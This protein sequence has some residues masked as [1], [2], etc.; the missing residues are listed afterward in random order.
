MTRSQ[1][2]TLTQINLNDLVS[3]FGWEKQPLPAAI[4]RRIFIRPARTFAQ[5]MV[6]FDSATGQAGLAEAS[7]QTLRAHYVKDLRVHGNKNI[8]ANGPTLFLSNH[9]G[10][11]D[12]LALFSAINRPDL[13]IIA[14][15]RPFLM[16]L[17]NVSKQLSYIS[18]DSAERIRTT[19]QISS[20]LRNEGSALT[21]PAGEIEPDPTVYGDA[22]DSLDNWTDSAAV[23]IRFA[24]DT[25]IVP[26]L[27]SGVVWDKAVRHFLTR[28]KRT[29]FER[30]KLAAAIQVFPMMMSNFRPTTVHVQFAKPITLDEVGS[31]DTRAIHEVIIKRMRRLIQN[32]PTDNGVSAL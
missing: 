10:M 23:F 26:V 6:E 28:I 20:H 18:D 11:V 7:M 5:Q 19:R 21:F 17:V 9:P 12:T 32:K 4:L 3:S 30:D 8:P 15:H 25:K 14:V 29:R 27:V 2:D 1:L 24:R 31:T 13:R 22:E 16:S